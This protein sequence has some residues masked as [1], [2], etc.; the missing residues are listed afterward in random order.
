LPAA[1]QA[2]GYD[3]PITVDKGF[4]TQ[5]SMSGRRITVILLDAGDTD[6]D[7]LVSLAQLPQFETAGGGF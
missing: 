6:I 2:A 1:A 4:A 3:A 5:Q 7:G